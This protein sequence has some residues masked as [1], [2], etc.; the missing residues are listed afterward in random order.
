MK[1]KEAVQKSI[2]TVITRYTHEK[3]SLEKGNLMFNSNAIHYE[4]SNQVGD[5]KN[6]FLDSILDFILKTL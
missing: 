2:I 5:D 1:Q 6:N 3:S 4:I